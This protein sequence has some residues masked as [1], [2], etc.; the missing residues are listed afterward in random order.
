M[1]Y[2]GG[3]YTFTGS[4]L[5]IVVDSVFT[6]T[7]GDR[8]EAD[9]LVVIFT[10]GQAHDA[11]EAKEYAEIL[12]KRGVRILGIGAGP[13]LS[14]FISELEQ[15]V[16][17]PEDLFTFTFKNLKEEI[18]RAIASNL[19]EQLCLLKQA[20]ITTET[21]TTES[22]IPTTKATGICN[23]SS[24]YY[25]IFIMIDGS[26]ARNVSFN[27][28]K[29]YLVNFVQNANIGYLQ[30]RLG[31]LQFSL[32]HL[33]SIVATF[34]GSQEKNNLLN[35]IDNMQYQQGSGRFTG[36][37]LEL[38]ERQI[39]SENVENRTDVKN[40]LIVISYGSSNDTSLAQRIAAK[41]S[42]RVHIFIIGVELSSDAMK[43]EHRSLASQVDDFIET[44]FEE[45]PKVSYELLRKLCHSTT[46]FTSRANTTKVVETAESTATEAL[47]TE[48]T[49]T[50]TVTT[51]S[52]TTETVTTDST[53]TEDVTTDSTTT[54]GVTTDSTTTE[55]VTTKS[56]TT[57]AVT[58]ESTTTEAVTTQSTSTEA[59]T[60][61]STTTEGVTTESTTTEAVTTQSTTTEAVTTES[62]TTETV[63][64]EST[65]TEAL[66]TE[67][68][69]TEGVTTDST[70]TE[71]VTT[72]STTTEAVTTESTTTETVTTESTTTE[73][74]TTDSTTTEG[75]TTEST[76][77]ED[78]TTDNSTTTEIAIADKITSNTLITKVPPTGIMQVTDCM[79]RDIFLA[80]DGTANVGENNF[81]KQVNFLRK[82]IESVKLGSNKV[83]V[84]VLE[85]SNIEQT[86]TLFGFS[87][88]QNLLDIHNLL[89][90][91]PYYNTP[92]RHVGHALKMIYNEVFT[93]SGGD[94]FS[95]EDILIV[96]VNGR[97]QDAGLASEFSE[98]LKI[99]GVRIIAV[100]LGNETSSFEDQMELLASSFEDVRQSSF[101]DLNSVMN[102]VLEDICTLVDTT[103]AH[104]TTN[105]R[106]TLTTDSPTKK[107]S[108]NSQKANDILY[109]VDTTAN[110]TDFWMTKMKSFISYS[111]NRFKKINPFTM[112]GIMQF[113][114]QSSVKIIKKLARDLIGA[115]LTYH[116]EKLQPSKVSKRL[117][118]DALVEAGK[119]FYEVNTNYRRNDIQDVIILF[120]DGHANDHEK[121]VQEVDLLK[122]RKI[123]I[124]VISFGEL[125]SVVDAEWDKIV[126]ETYLFMSTLEPLSFSSLFN[127]IWEPICSEVYYRKNFPPPSFECNDKPQDIYF[128]VDGSASIKYTNFR[129]V[130]K[131]LQ[132]LVVLLTRQNNNLH[133]GIMQYSEVSKN[134]KILKMEYHT[135][136]E[137]LYAVQSIKYHAGRKTYTGNAL[138]RVSTEVF[139]K[140][141]GDRPLVN[142]TLILM[143]DGQAHD[144]SLAHQMADA[145]KSRRIKI[146]GVAAGKL[147]QIKHFKDE[148]EEM[149]TSKDDIITVDFVDLA[150]YATKLLRITC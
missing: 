96:L 78:V 115:N 94:R 85:I 144:L 109:M 32:P 113:N 28:V 67:S 114:G 64:T 79:E 93:G 52:T 13:Y 119:T 138:S 21:V 75:V 98:K 16:S 140:H 6:G 4:A 56:T 8:P 105:G 99:R 10:D 42:N 41:L 63:T 65:T 136:E 74:V 128:V 5:K 61:E 124:I 44:T 58:T 59:L 25:D 62:T 147:E 30:S 149:V 68:T 38:V 102:Y 101:N 45:L 1:T 143:T 29:Q 122:A 3:R 47:T 84:G 108:C 130:R 55:A 50:E 106:I 97:T 135:R 111:M 125:R 12:K 7:G 15:M 146:L 76:T 23:S 121:V 148:L 90:N 70:T 141:G 57:E 40:I 92:E 77:T 72:Q 20:K 91:V 83:R 49:T 9:N 19:T 145:L 103:A 116:L 129:S 53:T 131:L 117:T 33:A 82:F 89:K 71:A 88:S 81:L 11:A 139:N 87:S 126:N 54:E 39:F 95:V 104:K 17:G 18:G 2:H 27:K 14:R 80:I 73:G 134:E 51:E 26:T 118:G 69:T 24:P 34:G 22:T 127:S 123:K 46:F 60:T 86:H 36:K 43:V 66:T 142:D 120:T 132:D 112:M 137:I 107:K 35:Y 48:S 31:I 133:I 110:V 150:T 37:A 100:A